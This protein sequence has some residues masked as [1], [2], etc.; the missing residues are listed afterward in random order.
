MGLLLHLSDYA[1]LRRVTLPPAGPCR[2]LPLG[3][4]SAGE[5]VG[6]RWVN[7]RGE[8]S[9]RRWRGTYRSAAGEQ[10]LLDVEGQGPVWYDLHRNEPVQRDRRTG[11]WAIERDDRV[12]LALA[13]S[14]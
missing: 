6:L 7:R 10:V 5:T 2:V 3:G 14:R 12:R 13:A 4:V 11:W 1:H 9:E 8:P